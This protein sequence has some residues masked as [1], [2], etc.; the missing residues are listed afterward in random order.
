MCPRYLDTLNQSMRVVY[1]GLS[2][3]LEVLIQE[4][5]IK[6]QVKATH[7][8]ESTGNLVRGTAEYR[9]DHSFMVL[10]KRL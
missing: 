4:S 10:L 1:A 2:I 3:G 9:F 7:L 6:R 8:F 5:A